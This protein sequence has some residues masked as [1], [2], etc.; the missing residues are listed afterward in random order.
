[1]GQRQRIALAR[2]VYGAPQRAAPASAPAQAVAPVAER[3]AA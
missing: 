2:A 1:M 3:V